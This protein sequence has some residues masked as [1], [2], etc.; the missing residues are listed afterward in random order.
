MYKALNMPS[1]MTIDGVSEG[2]GSGGCAADYSG[3]INRLPSSCLIEWIC[4]IK[5]WHPS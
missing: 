4:Y 3:V 2:V 5:N 1:D